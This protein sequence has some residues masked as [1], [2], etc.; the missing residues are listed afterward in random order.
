MSDSSIVK[1]DNKS[2]TIAVI[3]ILL[4]AITVAIIY[5][6]WVMYTCAPKLN[7]NLDSTEKFS[8]S[9]CSCNNN[10]SVINRGLS[11]LNYQSTSNY[12]PNRTDR[13]SDKEF[14]PTVAATIRYI[15]QYKEGKMNP[16]LKGY[17]DEY[18]QQL[19]DQIKYDAINKKYT[20]KM[21]LDLDLNQTK[22]SVDVT[23][24]LDTSKSKEP[25]NRDPQNK[26][27]VKVIIYHMD[28]CGHCMDIMQKIQSNGKT[29]YQTIKDVFSKVPYVSIVDYK[30]GRDKEADRYN[31]FP[32]IVIATE[33]GEKEYNGPR[34]V[35]SISKAIANAAMLN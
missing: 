11:D 34:D 20:D 23:D 1:T 5:N 26:S 9:G 14:S 8:G 16:E 12:N 15:S 27:P 7:N 2:T 22:K 13:L 3:L 30:Y 21:K 35:I 10:D 18:A 33:E 25:L 31:S 28:G 19:K 4:I 29:K 6:H 17:Y 32:V 24:N